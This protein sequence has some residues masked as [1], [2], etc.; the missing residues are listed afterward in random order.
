[1]AIR[2]PGISMLSALALAA[3]T[4]LT[5][6][7]V[8]AQQD[9]PHAIAEF[10]KADSG[11]AHWFASAYGYA[12]FPSVGKGAIGIGGARGKGWV[13]E[14]GAL[15]GKSTL[16]QV[17]IGLQLGG[18]AYREVI[19]FKDETALKDFCR[20]NFEL[21]AQASAVAVTAGVSANAKYNGGVAIFTMAKGGLMYEASVGGQKFS[22]KAVK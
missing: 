11:I 18:Q 2:N 13:Y 22:F 15:I 1:M 6:R 4:L 9:V 7:T 20:G 8:V 19:F 5:P 3:G 14:R 21:S 10:Q 16:T 12:I 17:T